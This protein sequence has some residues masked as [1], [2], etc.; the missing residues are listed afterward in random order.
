MFVFVLAATALVALALAFV[1]PTLWTTARRSAITMLL[2]FP[3]GAA[4][5]YALFGTPD[6]LDPAQREAPETI[7]A[8]I[9]QLEQRLQREPDNI[10]AWVL[11]GRTRKNQG[12]EADNLG[13]LPTATRHY[14]DAVQA[15]RRARDLAPEEVDLQ[16]EMAE[17]LLLADVDRRFGPEAT[18]LLDLVLARVPNHERALWLRGI[19]AVQAGDAATAVARWETLLPMVQGADVDDLRAQ[20]ASARASAGMPPMAPE[21]AGT[22][23]AGTP[24]AELA[25]GTTGTITVQIDADPAMI[26]AL[27]PQA[28]L[29]VTAYNA[30]AAGPP[31]AV[32]RL[33][34]VTL[35]LT[36]TLSDADQFMPTAKLSAT[37]RL[38]VSARFARSG[39]VEPDAGDLVATP[40]L[41]E[42]ANAR[43]ITL[44]LAPGAA[45]TGTAS[46]PTPGE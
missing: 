2:A 12:R 7:E 11:L 32:K 24:S 6:A 3:L 14:M 37:A 25:P 39:T 28:V 43:P 21:L 40:V 34:G 29:F 22:P 42:L 9:F 45:T 46:P 1:L 4:G 17:A 36:V 38:R 20:I 44:R 41:V 19:A 30:D 33:Q 5:L 27:P 26:A 18:G 16:V 8:S 10:E 35:P 31:V 15:M 23:S 13:D